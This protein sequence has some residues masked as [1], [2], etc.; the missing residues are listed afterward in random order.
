MCKWQKLGHM[1]VHVQQP[2]S[3]ERDVVERCR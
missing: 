3:H 2:H 1:M